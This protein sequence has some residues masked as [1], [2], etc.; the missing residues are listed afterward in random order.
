MI[1]KAN[2]HSVE[3]R[4]NAAGGKGFLNIEHLLGAA[5]LQNQ[6]GLFAHVT[7]EPNSSLGYHEHH[8]EGESYYILR[9][10]GLY[11]DNGTPVQVKAGDVVFCPDGE[12]HGIENT[13]ADQPLEFVA[14]IIKNPA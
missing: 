12:G 13:S 6:C 8:G 2:E 4:E 5:Q 11:S 9:G 14:L 10:T 1:F 7:I 3:R